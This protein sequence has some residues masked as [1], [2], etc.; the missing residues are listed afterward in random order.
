MKKD[1]KGWL[2]FISKAALSLGLAWFAIIKADPNELMLSLSKTNFI[3]LLSALAAT[4]LGV[5]VVQSLEIYYSVAEK[6][7]LT[8]ASLLK[9]NTSM[10]FY[11][12]FLPSALTLYIRWKKYNE[13][14][15]DPYASATLVGVHKIL[16]I[17]TAC[18]FTLAS[19]LLFNKD[20]FPSIEEFT[21]LVSAITAAILVPTLVITIFKNQLA[22]VQNK[23][24]LPFKIINKILGAINKFTDLSAS[25]KTKVIFYVVVQHFLFVAS[26]W[27]LLIHIFPE[28]SFISVL[29][30][31]SLL[32][33]LLAFPISVGGLGVREIIFFSLFPLFGVPPAEALTASLL[34]FLIN[35]LIAF[36]GGALELFK[37]IRQLLKSDIQ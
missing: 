28:T 27:I 34:L 23:T 9:I 4:F 16:Q 35:V 26:A 7:K 17:L 15:V 30:I 1:I 11:S 3:T 32:V 33:I 21:Y 31:R 24:S 2:V 5:V 37:P 36:A 20:I 13:H 12:L 22:F 25:N 19:V 8:I 6:G 14:E 29:F 10:M 18:L